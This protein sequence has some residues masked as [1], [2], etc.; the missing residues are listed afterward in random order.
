MVVVNQ[1]GGLEGILTVDDLLTLFAE[2]FSALARVPTREQE[3]EKQLR[4]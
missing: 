4:E 1:T 2:E 3:R